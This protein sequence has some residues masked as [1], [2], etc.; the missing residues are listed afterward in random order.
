MTATVRLEARPGP[1][2][3]GLDT[4][5]VIVND[6]QNA[7]VSPGG[8]LDKAGF[9]I[10]G[11]GAVVDAVDTTLEAARAAGL[12]V[13][14]FRNGF[15]AELHAAAAGSP[16][17]VK[18]HAL[19]LMRERP[20]LEGTLLIRGSWDHDIVDA[21]T[22]KPGD[23][24]V[25]KTRPSC[26]AG[27]ELQMMLNARGIRGIVVVGIASNVGVEWTLRDGLSREFFGIMLEDATMPAGPGYL[28]AATVFNVETF[29]GWVST[30]AAFA[31]AFGAGR[32]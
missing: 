10:A 30:S 19:R 9:D 4:S 18:S 3:L 11:A 20:E 32:R 8:Y 7:F 16:W 1:I 21:L 12:P 15:D 28:Q 26:F 17:R 6:M 24:V 13:F 27:T 2:E 31:D 14:Y 29:I 25:D 22:P 23:V 5:A